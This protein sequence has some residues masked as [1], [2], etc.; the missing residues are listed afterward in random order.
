MNCG[1][2]TAFDRTALKEE[3]KHAFNIGFPTDLDVGDKFLHLEF[4][5]LL[6]GIPTT[7]SIIIMRHDEMEIL[8]RLRVVYQDWCAKSSKERQSGAG[9]EI[10]KFESLSALGQF[11]KYFILCC[12]LVGIQF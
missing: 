8:I 1:S 9:L 6:T 10:I 11:K 4:E 12:A 5:D 7:I 2:S 3:R